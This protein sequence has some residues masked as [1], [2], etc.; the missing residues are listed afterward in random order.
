FWLHDNRGNPCGNLEL[1]A[2]LAQGDRP[3]HPGAVAEIR[4]GGASLVAEGR[5]RDGDTATGF[6]LACTLRSAH[7]C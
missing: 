7:A 6:A 1:E 5:C 2:H 3:H 4:R